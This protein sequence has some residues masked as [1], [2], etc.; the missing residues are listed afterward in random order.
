M[1]YKDMIIL[2]LNEYGHAKKKDI[3]SLLWDKLPDVLNDKQKE[4]KILTLLTSL[5][6]EGKIKTDSTNKQMSNWILNQ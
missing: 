5:R 6:N 2:Y 4:R 3:K 1:Y